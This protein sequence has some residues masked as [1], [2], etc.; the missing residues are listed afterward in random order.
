V[1]FIPATW[2]PRLRPWPAAEQVL[3]DDRFSSALAN[4]R[5][6]VTRDQLRTLAAETNLH[7]PGHVIRAFT[8][9][10]IWGSG[11]RSRSYR[12]LP[13]ALGSGNCVDQLTSAAVKCRRGELEAAYREMALPGIGP[14]FFTKWFAFCGV[15][16][17]TR[18]LIL[19]ARVHRTLHRT[20]GIRR[21][22]LGHR[23]SGAVRYRAYVDLLHEWA[24]QLRRAGM[25]VDAE[26]VEFALFA[27]NGEAL[28]A[29]DG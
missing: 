29:V 16:D 12:N 5:R 7:D 25:T 21:D 14:A 2:T 10:V 23:A 24:A 8:L 3:L 20:L 17:G 11:T 19:D 1:T 22:E 18:P 4:T 9:I 15:G 26:Q 6:T 13:R 28:P 27:H